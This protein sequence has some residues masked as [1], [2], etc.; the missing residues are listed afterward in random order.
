MSAVQDTP[1]AGGGP[2]VEASDVVAQTT[3]HWNV[4]GTSVLVAWGLSVAGGVSR[5]RLAPCMTLTLQIL[6]ILLYSWHRKMSDSSSF[7][8]I[9]ESR[10]KHCE[11]VAALKAD[12]VFAPSIPTVRTNLQ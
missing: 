9:Y 12:G 10:V 4:S 2:V 3:K 8:M 5:L 1:T 6:I 11:R 7:R